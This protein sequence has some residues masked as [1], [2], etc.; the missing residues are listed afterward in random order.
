MTDRITVEFTVHRIGGPDTHPERV[1]GPW[2]HDVTLGPRDEQCLTLHGRTHPQFGVRI[3]LYA[4]T[5]AFP[6]WWSLQMELT[7]ESGQW[8]GRERPALLYAR[9]ADVPHHVSF[10]SPGLGVYSVGMRRTGF[11]EAPAA[12]SDFSGRT[13][14]EAP[15]DVS[16]ETSSNFRPCGDCHTPI[17]CSES[18][19]DRCP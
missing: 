4:I 6:D 5:P 15:D 17:T 9:P 13:G 10:Q 8:I 7:D 16:R 14:E 12:S 11:W 1:W 2:L 18:D 19:E 3:R